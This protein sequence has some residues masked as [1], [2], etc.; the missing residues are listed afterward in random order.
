MKEIRLTVCALLFLVASARAASWLDD[1]DAGL[2]AVRS[3]D[4]NAVVAKM[5]SAIEQMP[6]ESDKTRTYAAVFL[7]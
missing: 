1:Y 5:T 3:G 4:W 7:S 6:D 2:K